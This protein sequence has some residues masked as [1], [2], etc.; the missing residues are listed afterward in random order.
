MMIDQLEARR[1]LA[2]TLG[3]TKIA[4]LTTTETDDVVV[5][6]SHIVKEV[7]ADGQRLDTQY[8]T[9]LVNDVVEADFP[10][11]KA[12]RLVVN[13][14]GGDD[15]FIFGRN[16]VLPLVVNGGDGADTISGGDA[17]DTLDGGPG[18]DRVFGGIHD[19]VLICNEGDD[20]LAGGQDED[21]VD[22]TGRSGDM[23][24]TIDGIANDVLDEDVDLNGGTGFIQNDVETILGGSG[25]DMIDA[26]FS[27]SER[28]VDMRIDGNNGRDTLIGGDGDDTISGGRGNDSINGS[29]GNDSITGNAGRD[30]LLGESG[31]DTFNSAD[32]EKDTIDGGTGFDDFGP[33]GEFRDFLD[34]RSHM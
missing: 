9:I 5:V 19:D 26:S 21:T 18:V 14:L 31:A 4:T 34:V 11:Y 22:L 1:M 10:K 24:V 25:D 28:A 6:T 29:T 33:N 17:R 23:I 13:L 2:F 15:S 16:K 12:K 8:L 20:D 3:A 27:I 7:N 30:I 32:N